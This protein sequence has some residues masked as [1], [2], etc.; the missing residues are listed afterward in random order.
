MVKLNDT[1][2]TFTAEGKEIIL[3]GDLNCCFMSAH[4]NDT[5]CKQLKSI[6]KVPIRIFFFFG[7][8]CSS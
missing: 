5:D 6:F 8:S 4:Q 2:D 3:C 1:F 7:P